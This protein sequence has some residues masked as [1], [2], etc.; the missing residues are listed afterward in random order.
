MRT[1]RYVVTCLCLAIPVGAA[2]VVPSALASGTWQVTAFAPKH[3]PASESIISVA[4]SATDN[5]W[6]L[7]SLIPNGKLGYGLVFRSR[8]G[9][10]QAVNL[11][12][13]VSRADQ[14]AVYDWIG[15]T[16]PTNVWLLGAGSTGVA[17]HWNGSRWSTTNLPGCCNEMVQTGAALSSSDAWAFGGIVPRLSQTEHPYVARLRRGSWRQVRLPRGIADLPVGILAASAV[18]RTDIWALVQQNFAISAKAQLIHWNGRGWSRLR[19]PA[20]LVTD[21]PV[22]VLAT[23]PSSVWVGAQA[24][25]GL[26]KDIEALW[27]W[28]PGGWVMYQIPS[29][30]AASTQGAWLA[31]SLARDGHGGLWVLGFEIN[32]GQYRVW[33][34]GGGQWIGPQTVGSGP[35]TIEGLVSVPRT[36]TVLGYG[37]ETGVPVQDQLGVIAKYL[38]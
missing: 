27:H 37:S 22:T 9:S 20:A 31:A 32:G 35:I 3:G 24:P 33:D 16:S 6:A 13:K 1:S 4:A 15:T 11:P 8:G 38:P 17:A 19:L 29:A 5:A 14:G 34:F 18:S 21:F 30:V 25:N 23:G 12:R 28:T 26:D 10:W 36:S 7:G 2:F